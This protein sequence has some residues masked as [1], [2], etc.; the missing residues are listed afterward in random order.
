MFEQHFSITE[1]ESATLTLEPE[2]FL[3][4]E[5]AK[6]YLVESC[7]SLAD[8]SA[9][10]IAQDRGIL[11]YDY[12]ITYPQ[13]FRGVF[14]RNER[15]GWQLVPIEVSYDGNKKRIKF[16]NH[17][18]QRKFTSDD[19]TDKHNGI[20]IK[21][22]D[23]SNLMV[24]DF[25]MSIE[26]FKIL[27]ASLIHGALE[28]KPMVNTPRGFHIY[29][30]NRYAQFWKKRYNLHSLT[31]VN[32]SLGIDVR[33]R[34]AGVIAPKTRIEGYGE[35]LW[36]LHPTEYIIEYDY[37]ALIPLMD[38]IY[39]RSEEAIISPV[40]TATPKILDSTESDWVKAQNIAAALSQMRIDY[41]DWVKLGMAI[42]A[43]FGEQGKYLWDYFLSNP[44]YQDT[45]RTIDTHWRSFRSVNRV[46]LASLFYIADKYGIVQ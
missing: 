32:K 45:Q 34:N 27:N 4:P 18:T 44:N 41:R 10:M 46:T 28:H 35:Y 13:F 31:T 16:P 30:T 15:L 22:G 8:I 23:P 17:W 9:R 25:D 42:Y 12:G 37:Q 24:L 5:V 26:D 33:E 40:I 7:H 36:G 39:R 11:P 29:L 43:G 38:A 14:Y 6:A 19:F 21:T 2:D 1:P 20:F 3:N